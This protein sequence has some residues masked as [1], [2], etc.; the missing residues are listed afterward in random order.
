MLKI[1]SLK[2]DL[3]LRELTVKPTDQRLA[4]KMNVALKKKSSKF[5]V[6]PS[7]SDEISGA[8]EIRT[9]ISATKE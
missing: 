6:P 3:Y 1:K 5:F 8:V 4:C 2:E 9:T 7:T